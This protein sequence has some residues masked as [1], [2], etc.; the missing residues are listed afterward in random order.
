MPTDSSWTNCRKWEWFLDQEQ[1]RF[2]ARYN[3]ANRLRCAI[4]LKFLET[5]ARFPQSYDEICEHRLQELCS[6]LN[7]NSEELGTY[8]PQNGTSIRH[9]A[10]IR[11]FLGFRPPTTPDY[12]VLQKWLTD[13]VIGVVLIDAQAGQTN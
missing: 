8:D 4:L 6:V 2:I 7:I 1:H 10:A 13:D 11:S 3:G 12:A 5:E 9:R